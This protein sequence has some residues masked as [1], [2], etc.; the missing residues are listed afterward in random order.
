MKFKFVLTGLIISGI[1]LSTGVALAASDKNKNVQIPTSFVYQAINKYKDKNYTGCI[2]DMDYIIQKGRPTDVAYYYKA[3]SYSQL[4]MPDKARESYEAARS[5][6]SNRILID[7]ATQAVNCIDDSTLCDYNLDESDISRFIKS[8]EFMHN[9]V[10][11]E[12][13]N[14]A[15]E[16]VK[17]EINNDVKPSEDNINKIN[18][19]NQPTDKEI[20]DAVR[21]FAKLGISPYGLT[22]AIGGMN[23]E[24]AQINAMFGN[25]GSNNNNLM[26][27]IPM[28]SAM[29]SNQNGNSS[30]SKEFVQAYMMNQMLPGLSFSSSD[31]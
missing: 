24:I 13:E 10:K 15:L 29:S 25:N 14:Q 16:R 4:G 30:V 22:G 2:Q 28:L 5:I 1:I 31:K 27:L 23:S 11:T 8:N 9:D 7:Y 21:T 3:I 26:N 18:L 17:A 6:S 20:A 19:N 12:L